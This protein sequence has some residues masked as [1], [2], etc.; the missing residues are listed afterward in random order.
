MTKARLLKKYLKRYYSIKKNID[1]G[2]LIQVYAD[3]TS[4]DMIVIYVR[5]R[6]F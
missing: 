3:L 1:I 6:D 2:R 4:I 5:T